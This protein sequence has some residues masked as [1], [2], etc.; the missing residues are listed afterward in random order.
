MMLLRYESFELGLVYSILLAPTVVS[1]L[2]TVG[3]CDLCM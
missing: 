3:L 2:W 1:E